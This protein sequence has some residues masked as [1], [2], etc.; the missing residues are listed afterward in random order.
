MTIAT[1]RCAWVGATLLG[2]VAASWGTG[3]GSR[4]AGAPYS[5][6][7]GSDD[8]GPGLAAGEASVSSLPVSV[9]PSGSVCAGQCVVLSAQASG[10]RA[11]YAY[12][13]S[14]GLAADGGAVRV[15]PASTTTYAVTATDSAGNAGGEFPTPDATGT[16]QTTVTVSDCPDTG[17]ACG[18]GGAGP[19]ASGHYV[20]VLT[21]GP[22]TEADSAGFDAGP[23]A[24]LTV[25][26]TVVVSPF[27]L[28]LAI[29]ESSVAQGGTFWGVWNVAVIAIAGSLDGTLDCGTGALDASIVD[30]IWG[31][32]G[33]GTMVTT[34]GTIQGS[35]TAV[36]AAG[37][38]GTITG[39]FDYTTSANS[40]CVGTYTATRQTPGTGP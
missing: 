13:W 1:P 36:P 22:G 33:T 38:T 26:S 16:A 4:A 28:D 32:P 35:L 39:V 19:P 29:D 7:V 8:G 24:G 11:P 31:L 6:D 12:A 2:S 15:C 20:G 27:T 25:A 3:C 14:H 17:R 18:P 37:A 10:G 21:C 9:T 40:K 30:G 34:S 5:L 23:D